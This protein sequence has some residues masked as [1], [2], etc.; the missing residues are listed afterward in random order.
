[1]A[2][3]KLKQHLRINVFFHYKKQI[4]TNVICVGDRED[5]L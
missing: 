3:K 5:D 2:F 4:L 1:M